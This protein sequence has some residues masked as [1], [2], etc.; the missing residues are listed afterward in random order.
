[1]ASEYASCPTALVDAPI[2]V[3]WGLLTEPARWGDFFDV[4]V[5]SVEPPGRAVVGQRC[6]GES[7]PRFLH[8][9]VVFEYTRIDPQEHGL[10][11]RVRLPLGIVVHEDLSCQA[12]G[13]RQCRVNYHCNFELPSGLRGW[14]VRR[15]MRR[16][17]DDGPRDSLSRLKERAELLAT[18]HTG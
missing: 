13:E 3:V 12:V 8:L 15:L 2:A 11:V 5:R 4:R 18:P 6:V 14:V 16:E 9:G 17:L 7:G 1:L 10:G